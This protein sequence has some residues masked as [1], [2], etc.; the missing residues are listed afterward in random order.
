MNP[1][2]CCCLAILLFLTCAATAADDAVDSDKGGW[3]NLLNANNFE[4]FKP[5]YGDWLWVESVSIDDKNPRRFAWKE[6]KGVA[7]NG[8][9]GGTRNLV[10]KESYQDVECHLEFAVPKGSNSGIKFI[11]RYE[12]QILDSFGKPKEKLTGSDCGGVYPRGENEPRYHTIDDGVPPKV[13][14]CKAPGEWQT[15]GIVFRAPRFD[16]EGK[17]TENAKFIKVTLN[18]QVIHEN[19]EVKH[20]TGAAWRL[21][22]EIPTGPVMLQ[23]DHGPVAFRNV[24]VR[25]LK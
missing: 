13:N 19:V 7:L 1:K 3:T 12:I 9:K 5:P 2:R 21:V 11:E 18:G 25:A 23:A 24:K 17:K 14:A 15:L 20:P 8:P 10:T 4:A 16:A 22:K 6:G